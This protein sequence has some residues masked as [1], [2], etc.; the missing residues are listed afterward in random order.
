MSRDCE[1]S[2][3][4]IREPG[5]VFHVNVDRTM[6][7]V[8]RSFN[9][10]QTTMLFDSLWHI[11]HAQQKCLQTCWHFRSAVIMSSKNREIVYYNQAVKK[12][13]HY[14]AI[15]IKV[16][17]ITAEVKSLASRVVLTILS[18]EEKY[19]SHRNCVCWR[20]TSIE[21][22]LT[23]RTKFGT[24][25]DDKLLHEFRFLTQLLLWKTFWKLRQSIYHW[26]LLK[27]FTFLTNCSI[28]Y[29]FFI[30]AI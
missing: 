18:T 1:N 19:V 12:W 22:E 28:S 5:A 14:F 16:Q 9:I 11:C 26:F 10:C 29:P 23:D 7:S 25:T 27:I 4:I 15:F 2:G 30:T 8:M 13:L 6:C 24:C 17:W 21:S 20:I 3:N